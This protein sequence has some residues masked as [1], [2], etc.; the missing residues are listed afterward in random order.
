MFSKIC[1]VLSSGFILNSSTNQST[2]L[3]YNDLSPWKFTKSK[4][5][6]TTYLIFKH[7]KNPRGCPLNDQTFCL[8]SNNTK[9]NHTN[10]KNLEN[11]VQVQLLCFDNKILTY[12]QIFLVSCDV[13]DI[14]Y[15]LSHKFPERGIT[16][17][18]ENIEQ[19]K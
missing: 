19:R 12:F 15:I 6:W 1:E 4:S 10:H 5:S 16:G 3:Q 17:K 8:F 11:Y 13:S 14:F 7:N 9:Q 18:T 2:T